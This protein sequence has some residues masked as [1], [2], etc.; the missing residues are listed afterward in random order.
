MSK[1]W[2]V[3]MS[4]G[5]LGK[6]KPSKS[7]LWEVN[8]CFYISI[9]SLMDQSINLSCNIVIQNA[10]CVF[11]YKFVAP[12]TN[13]YMMRILIVVIMNEAVK[14]RSFYLFLTHF[15]PIFY[16]YIPSKHAKTS[17]FSIFSGG[18]EVEHLLKIG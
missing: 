3:W 15:Q 6:R 1:L 2:S 16:F 13:F 10:G 7:R 18:T 9:V 8:L 17:D 14:F 11:G 5:F 12:I 4:F